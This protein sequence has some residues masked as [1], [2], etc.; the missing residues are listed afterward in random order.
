LPATLAFDHP[1]VTALSEFVH[2]TLAPAP[3]PPDEALQ[4]GI[5]RIE[6]ALAEHDEA[7]RARVVAVL[8][9]ALARLEGDADSSAGVQAALSD[10]SDDEIFA[11]IDTQL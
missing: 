4:A 5:D 7:T 9:S 10:A 3:P 11:F 2:R 6:G 8:H 1:T